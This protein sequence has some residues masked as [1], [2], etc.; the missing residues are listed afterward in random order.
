MNWHTDR[1]GSSHEL[2]L[3][4]RE[5]KL[6]LGPNHL[7]EVRD[8]TGPAVG[9]PVA[10]MK[11]TEAV[12]SPNDRWVITGAFSQI[13][14]RDELLE[15]LEYAVKARTSPSVLVLFGFRQL[16]E[17]LECLLEPDANL[18]L[19]RIARRLAD[20]TDLAAVLYEPRRGE[21]CGL[22]GGRPE[23]VEPLLGAI[24]AGIDEELN[25]FGILT[26]LGAVAL[27]CEATDPISALRLGDQR[28]EQIAGDLR[29]SPRRTAYARIMATL[30]IAK[31]PDEFV[32]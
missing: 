16:A 19:G 12:E 21:F 7:S 5:R 1:S 10:S 24:T 31:E 6:R 2:R 18:L 25:A 17:R 32:E 9:E 15:D 14:D 4:R 11:A 23:D 3:V 22:F 29:P 27:P 30:Q 13:H 20:S 8:E 28:R 26:A